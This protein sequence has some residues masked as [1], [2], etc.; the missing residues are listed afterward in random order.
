MTR[1]SALVEG[2]VQGG[3]GGLAVGQALLAPR[4]FEHVS[5]GPG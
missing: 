1:I 5:R 3:D 4:R 2:I